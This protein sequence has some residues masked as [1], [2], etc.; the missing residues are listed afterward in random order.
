VLLC[1]RTSVIYQGWSPID[2]EGLS[3]Q[4]TSHISSVS[5]HLN[6]LKYWGRH[7]KSGKWSHIDSGIRRKFDVIPCPH[8]ERRAGKQDVLYAANLIKGALNEYIGR[9]GGYVANGYLQRADNKKEDIVKLGRILKI[10]TSP[11]SQDLTGLWK[12]ARSHEAL[13][14]FGGRTKV[15]ETC[16]QYGFKENIPVEELVNLLQHE[17]E[18]H[19]QIAAANLR[20]KYG[21]RKGWQQ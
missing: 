14:K 12:E 18:L 7:P 4:V 13:I 16:S 17:H 5:Y 2:D 21:T 6:T 15:R 20:E 8:P 10:D 11:A 9:R 3:W 1:N 19:K